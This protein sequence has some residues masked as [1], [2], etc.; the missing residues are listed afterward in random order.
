MFCAE[1]SSDVLSTETLFSKYWYRDRENVFLFPLAL[2]LSL[3]QTS[4]VLKVLGKT[5]NLEVPLVRYG[6]YL[7]SD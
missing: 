7:A 2:F 4:I 1:I 6:P 3:S 5:R